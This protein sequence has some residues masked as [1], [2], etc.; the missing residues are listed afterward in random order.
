M[1]VE[2]SRLE[3]APWTNYI[4]VEEVPRVSGNSWWEMCEISMK[5][6]ILVRPDE[7]IGWRIESDMVRDPDSE[8]RRV[9]SQILCLHSD[10][11]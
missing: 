7:H 2:E 9:F 4:N 1:E 6:V 11:A 8:V 3:L 5:N 10:H